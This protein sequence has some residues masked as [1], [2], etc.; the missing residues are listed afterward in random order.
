MKRIITAISFA[1]LALP[2]FADDRGAP[3]DQSLIDR[4][5]P[6]PTLSHNRASSGASGSVTDATASFWATGPWANDYAFT[7]PPQ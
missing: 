1:A 5:I 2:A 6:A 4:G 3:Y 7:A